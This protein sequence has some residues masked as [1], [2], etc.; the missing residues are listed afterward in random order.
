MGMIDDDQER[1]LLKQKL[2]GEA[3]ATI[4]AVIT[5]EDLLALRQEASRVYVH[6]E[7]INYICDICEATRRQPQIIAGVSPRGTIALMRAAQSWYSTT[8]IF[9][10]SKLRTV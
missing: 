8:V 9:I 1:V 4:G 10:T 3:L 2:K 6:K 7:I 5:A